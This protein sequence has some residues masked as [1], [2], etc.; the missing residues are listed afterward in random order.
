MM[1][2]MLNTCLG[3]ACVT[4]GFAYGATNADVQREKDKVTNVE[5]E[6]TKENKIQAG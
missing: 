6:T 3:A 1:I 5:T 4:V 2:R